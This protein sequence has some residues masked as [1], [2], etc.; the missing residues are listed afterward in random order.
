MTLG[1]EYDQIPGSGIGAYTLDHFQ[2]TT[3]GE[4][5]GDLHL[6]LTKPM[7]PEIYQ[8]VIILE[9]VAFYP[10]P[11]LRS[12]EIEGLG[13]PI[14]WLATASTN[15]DVDFVVHGSLAMPPLIRD[16]GG[17]RLSLTSI[18]LSITWYRL[19]RISEN[20]IGG[21]WGRLNVGQNATSSSVLGPIHVGDTVD[22]VGTLDD[23]MTVSTAHQQWL[24]ENVRLP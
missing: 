24:F 10:I 2:L 5:T 11:D 9:G 18:H 15:H 16:S 19:E 7:A 3:D 22:L 6:S 17:H 8:D 20:G 1:E 23:R 13:D 12:H 4:M 14:G 21:F